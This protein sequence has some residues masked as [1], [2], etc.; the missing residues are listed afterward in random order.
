MNLAQYIHCI[1]QIGHEKLF[2]R[3]Q[4]CVSTAATCEVIGFELF[5]RVY[6]STTV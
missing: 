4:N 1:F 3:P 2:A 6:Q 5:I